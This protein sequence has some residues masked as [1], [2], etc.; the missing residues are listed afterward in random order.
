MKPPNV[1]IE[2][3]FILV[4]NSNFVLNTLLDEGPLDDGKTVVLNICTDL[5]DPDGRYW[6]STKVCTLVQGLLNRWTSQLDLVSTTGGLERVVSVH[7]ST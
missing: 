7:N 5:L 6:C 2:S 1:L 3:K 4:Q